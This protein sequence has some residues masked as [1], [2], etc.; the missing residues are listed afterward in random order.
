MWCGLRV[1]LLFGVIWTGPCSYQ[2]CCTWV[3][4][5]GEAAVNRLSTQFFTVNQPYLNLEQYKKKATLSPTCNPAAGTQN[6]STSGPLTL[7]WADP[8]KKKHSVSIGLDFPKSSPQ[9]MLTA[10][11]PLGSANNRSPALQRRLWL[12]CPEPLQEW[13]KAWDALNVTE[14][15]QQPHSFTL[16][17]Q[18]PAGLSFSI[19]PLT[20]V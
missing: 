16:N 4:R 7:N 17:K 10:A 12:V 9:T 13:G 15:P 5:V 19:I 20:A 1:L 6:H 11:V 8:W 3:H 18:M 14:P 2:K